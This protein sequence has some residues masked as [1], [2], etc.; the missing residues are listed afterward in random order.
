LCLI[1]AASAAPIQ[2]WSG[3]ETDVIIS[4]V[5]ASPAQ[6][7]TIHTALAAGTL[8]HAMLDT[9]FEGRSNY[10]WYDHKER[11]WLNDGVTVSSNYLGLGLGTSVMPGPLAVGDAFTHE[12][13]GM[14]EFQLDALPSASAIQ[15]QFRRQD[16]SNFWF[17]NLSNSGA[18]SL[19][20]TVS[21]TPTLRGTAAGVLVAGQRIVVD[22][23]GTTIRGYHDTTLDWTYASA[24]NFQ[25]ET[26]GAV[27]S[28]GTGGRASSLLSWPATPASAPLTPGALSINAALTAMGA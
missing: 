14:I 23:R 15:V 10:V 11:R 28:L 18:F 7:A 17:A 26:D 16:A 1:G 21:G 13:D 20:E 4:N 24:T 27:N 2:V 25:T 19:Y 8:T 9:I 12:A 6:Q 5:V 22:F 3:P